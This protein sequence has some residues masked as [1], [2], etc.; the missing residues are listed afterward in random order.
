MVRVEGHELEPVRP[1][2]PVDDVNP[3]RL[4]APPGH[5]HA[6]ELPTRRVVQHRHADFEVVPLLGDGRVQNSRA[7]GHG[8]YG[9]MSQRKMEPS[10]I[11]MGT[12]LVGKWS[13]AFKQCCLHFML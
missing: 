3:N 10:V 6:E 13:V 1:A 5:R 2:G 8:E 4:D 11:R 9:I 12:G 7:S